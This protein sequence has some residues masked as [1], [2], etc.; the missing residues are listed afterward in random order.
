M[1]KRVTLKINLFLP[2]KANMSEWRSEVT[3][4]VNNIGSTVPNAV[5]KNASFPNR[6]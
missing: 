1:V 5:V 3:I 4:E 2:S 6:K